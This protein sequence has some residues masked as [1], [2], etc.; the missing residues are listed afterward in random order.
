MSAYDANGNLT[1]DERDYVYEYD[2]WNRLIS[3]ST[4]GGSPTMAEYRY[5]V[6]AH[7]QDAMATVNTA[8]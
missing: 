6:C 7:R 4:M 5:T 3:I 8:P 2:G 1:D